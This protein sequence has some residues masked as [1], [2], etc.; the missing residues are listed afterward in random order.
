MNVKNKKVTV[1][2]NS[3]AILGEGLLISERYVFW[4]DIIN[5]ILMCYSFETKKITEFTISE[6]A[7]AIWKEEENTVYLVGESGMCT[8]HLITKKW[9]VVAPINYK[10]DCYRG[11]DGGVLFTDKYLF[12]T[13]QK[14]PSFLAGSLYLTDGINAKEVFKGIGIPNSFIKINDSEILISDSL[15][16]KIY[17]FEFSPISHEL[18]S[19]NLWLDLQ[20]TNYTPDGGCIDEEGNV[21][22]AMWDGACINKYNKDAILL[23]S[24]S[25]PAIRPTNCKLTNDM[26]FLF[27]TTATEGLSEELLNKYPASGSV[28]KIKLD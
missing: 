7:S 14:Q 24:F 13:M 5:K 16:K 12:G 6:Q 4:L 23:D 22:I 17:K 2:H 8:F 21:Y 9:N 10:N 26:K 20:S 18:I 15:C 1:F 19:Q 25:L 28:L 27:V 3:N 11:N